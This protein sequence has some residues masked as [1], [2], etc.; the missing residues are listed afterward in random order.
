[1]FLAVIQGGMSEPVPLLAQLLF[2]V[3]P[4]ILSLGSFLLFHNQGLSM[5]AVAVTDPSNTRQVKP[6]RGI[7]QEGDA[8]AASLG[9]NE[10]GYASS[11]SL[12][13]DCNLCRAVTTV[14]RN[15]Q[16]PKKQNISQEA[17]CAKF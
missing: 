13:N 4:L 5:E 2:P 11:L 16:L 3:A 7:P 12:S 15:G 6:F 10:S 1:M 8:G 14:E 9:K 17:V